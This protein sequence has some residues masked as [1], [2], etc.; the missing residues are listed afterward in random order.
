MAMYLG[1]CPVFMIMPIGHWSSNAF[2]WY[3]RKQVMGFSQ[4]MAKRMLSCQNFR[5]IPDIH[6][7]IQ[8]DNP[9]IRNHPDNTETRR[10][11]SGD[12]HRCIR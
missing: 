8:Q 5:H 12:L 1:E 6:T 2:L 7:R 3:I 11:V 10:N 4:N 9:R